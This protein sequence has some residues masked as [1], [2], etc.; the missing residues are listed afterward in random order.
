VLV[1]VDDE[2]EVGDADVVDD[3]EALDEVGVALVVG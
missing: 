3:V 2:E 1:A